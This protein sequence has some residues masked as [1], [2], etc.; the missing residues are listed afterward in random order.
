MGDKGVV[1]V[2]DV[3]D[4]EA[5]VAQHLVVLVAPEHDICIFGF[6]RE[7]MD[8]PSSVVGIA[9]VCRPPQ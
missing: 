3:Y 5:R 8:T 4:G 1:Y 7:N 2:N 6:Q 9:I